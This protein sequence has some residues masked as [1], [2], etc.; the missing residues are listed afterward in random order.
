MIATLGSERVRYSMRIS[1]VKNTTFL[2]WLVLI[3]LVAVPIIHLSPPEDLFEVENAIIVGTSAG[4]AFS[5]APLAWKALKLPPH[6]LKSEYAYIIS[7]FMASSAL[8]WIFTLQW[9]W[10]A[11][12]LEWAAHGKIALWSRLYLALGLLMA[13]TT[14]WTDEGRVTATS[15]QR[16]LLFFCV[17]VGIALLLIYIGWGPPP[18]IV[19]EQMGPYSVP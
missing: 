16:T 6:R 13:L 18:P 1:N 19:L 12:G 14:I 15:W 2:A 9:L 8:A 17:S 5:Y 3:L 7:R 4:V 11:F 10:R